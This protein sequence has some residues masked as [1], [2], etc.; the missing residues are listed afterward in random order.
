MIRS[1][2]RLVL[3]G[4]LVWSA[5]TTVFVRSAV[6]AADAAVWVATWGAPPDQAGPAL[7]QQTIR[8]VIQTSVR[9][10]KLRVRLSNLYGAGPVTIGPVRVAKSAGG[11]AI[12]A[13][14]DRAVT[15]AGKP[16][17]TIPKGGDVL[18]DPVTF[19]AGAL[20]ALAISLYLP[21]PVEA[22]TI[23][24]V[25]MQT[26]FIVAG[27]STTAE[28]LPA[29]ETDTS[30]YFLTD[31]DVE[32]GADARTFVIVGD[33]VTDGVGS[34]EDKNARWPD[35]L[36]ARLQR[37]PALKSIAVINSG[38]AGNRILN[39]AADPFIGPSTLSRFDRDALSKPGVRW[40]LLLQGIN[41]ISASSVL[42][43]PK[44]KVSA[45]QIIEGMKTLIAR[46]RARKI[47]IWAGTLLPRKG[48]QAPFNSPENEVKRRAVNAWIRS[49]GAFDAVID[50]EKAVQDP[51]DPDRQLP[52][53]DSGDHRHPNDAGYKAMADA[54]DLTLFT[55]QR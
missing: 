10:S 39:D 31:V 15:F 47:Q 32:A 42:T 41:D 3:V 36:A 1:V 38:I 46:A 30:R 50:F 54:L 6:A 21:S 13:G 14:T 11:S 4:L 25:A 51:A 43:D 2:S 34:S 45:E 27:D 20:D 55:K 33:S 53:F 48:V 49:S 28:K 35:A 26:A 40:V 29:G 24:G 52:R 9:G 7:K 16:S 44:Q 22:S 12:Q 19:H 37:D 18:S 23:H 8:Q 5:G 17:V